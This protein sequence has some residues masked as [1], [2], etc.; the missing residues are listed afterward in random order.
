[1]VFIIFTCT[2]IYS[3]ESDANLKRDYLNYNYKY[4][5][6]NKVQLQEFLKDT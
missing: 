1:M 3:Q 6:S 2:N 5:D 4:L